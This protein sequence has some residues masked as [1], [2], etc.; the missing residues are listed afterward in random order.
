MDYEA[1]CISDHA[2][3]EVSFCLHSR[4][5]G[6]ANAVPRHICKHPLYGDLIL[7]YA[8]DLDLL[9]SPK[10]MQLP[11]LKNII[12]EASRAVRDHLITHDA[13]GVESQRMVVAS[14]ARAVWRQDVRLANRLLHSSPLAS[15]LLGVSGC[16]VFLLDPPF[17]DNLF[18]ETRHS[19][20]Q[21][22]LQ[23]LQ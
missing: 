10:H 7:Q 5:K 8:E 18:N 21:E 1:N 4:Q 13:Q 3:L 23:S 12:L 11:L 6:A 16:T 20:K 9:E 22:H 2:A 19:Q 14:V 17:L 15:T